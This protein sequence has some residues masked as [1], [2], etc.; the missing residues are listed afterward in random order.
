MY[1]SL[2]FVCQTQTICRPIHVPA[3]AHFCYL[4]W[5]YNIP[6]YICATTSVSIPV[7]GHLLLCIKETTNENLLYSTGNP[8]Q[9][10]AVA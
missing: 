2:Y 10:S 4:L 5:L 3:M 7:I 1:F 8:T 6:L 9:S